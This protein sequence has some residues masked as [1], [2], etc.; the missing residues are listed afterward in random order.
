MQRGRIA[1][2]WGIGIAGYAAGLL[3]ST[4]F[5]WPS[6]AVI[7]WTLAIVGLACYP[8]ARPRSA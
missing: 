7:V 5:D 3:A 4:A 6:G 8:F 1:A 2:A